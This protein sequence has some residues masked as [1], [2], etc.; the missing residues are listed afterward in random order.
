MYQPRSQ[1]MIWLE[2]NIPSNVYDGLLNQSDLAFTDLNIEADSDAM[3]P[4][5]A[6]MI[7]VIADIEDSGSGAG[8]DVHLEFRKDATATVFFI[9]SVAG[10][11]NDVHNHQSGLQPC[12]ENGDVDIHYDAS[13]AST[14]DINTFECHGVQVN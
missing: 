8:L 13:G 1:E 11:P 14:L 4:K 5:G 7:A 12:D 2:K 3:L 6:K 9:N 10:K